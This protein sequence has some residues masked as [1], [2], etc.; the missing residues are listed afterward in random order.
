LKGLFWLI[1]GLCVW[2]IPT[3]AF[4]IG[5]TSENSDITAE[6]AV[7]DIPQWFVIV[8]FA[9]ALPIIF[10]G[11]INIRKERK[12]EKQESKKDKKKSK[13]KK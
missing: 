2:F 1:F 6:E 7:S 3:I 5:V 12:A 11:V 9:I 10:K 4:Q 13:K 8:L